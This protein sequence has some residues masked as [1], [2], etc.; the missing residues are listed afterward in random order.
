VLGSEVT[1][2]ATGRTEAAVDALRK[3]GIDAIESLKP[4]LCG[5]YNLSLASFGVM[6]EIRRSLVE[7]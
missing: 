5:V 2:S 7:A 1:R 4:L 6:S 3:P